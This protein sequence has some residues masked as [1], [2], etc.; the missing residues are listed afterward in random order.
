MSIVRAID[1]YYLEV[2][3]DRTKLMDIFL[4]FNDFMQVGIRD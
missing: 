2:Q 1:T 4:K 3:Q